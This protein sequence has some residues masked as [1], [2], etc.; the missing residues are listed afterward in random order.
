M[1]DFLKLYQAELS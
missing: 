1:G